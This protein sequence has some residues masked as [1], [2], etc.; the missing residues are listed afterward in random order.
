[1]L[2]GI[3]RAVLAQLLGVLGDICKVSLESHLYNHLY[4]FLL[5][6]ILEKYVAYRGCARSGFRKVWF[7]EKKT[8]LFG[9]NASE[10]PL[11]VLEG[12]GQPERAPAGLQRPQE[13]RFGS[14]CEIWAGEC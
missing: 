10:T 4:K 14:R 5:S 1:M 13:R 9:P 11:E 2:S 12:T 7:Y 6:Y 3:R 8:S